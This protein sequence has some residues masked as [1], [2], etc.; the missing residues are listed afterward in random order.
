MVAPRRRVRGVNSTGLLRPWQLPRRLALLK[1]L[2]RQA[3]QWRRAG[4]E[5]EEN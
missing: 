3:S 1:Q 2:S 4:E 5:E